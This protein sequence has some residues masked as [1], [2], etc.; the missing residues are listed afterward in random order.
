MVFRGILWLQGLY[1]FEK[2]VIILTWF[3]NVHA[4][5]N[6][7]SALQGVC[8]VLGVGLELIVIIRNQDLEVVVVH[9][10]LDDVD[11]K[12]PYPILYL[13]PPILYQRVLVRKRHFDHNFGLD[14]ISDVERT[15]FVFAQSTLQNVDDRLFHEPHLLLLQDENLS[16]P[17]PIS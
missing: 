10:I 3:L 14:L 8:F 4:Y 9:V 6:T 7:A 11:M 1:N 15:I 13:N 5:F 2:D 16:G 17:I 12:R